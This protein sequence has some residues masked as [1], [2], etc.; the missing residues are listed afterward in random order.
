MFARVTQFEMNAHDGNLLAVQTAFERHV[1]PEL[2]K[3]P[4][5]EGCYFLQTKRNKATVVSLWESEETMKAAESSEA[6]VEQTEQQLKPLLGRHFEVESYQ[7]A[8]A[9]HPLD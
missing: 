7:V 5:Y 4:G 1:V 8:Y 2:R 9:E 6:Y 3:L